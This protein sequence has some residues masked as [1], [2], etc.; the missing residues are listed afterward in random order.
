VTDVT[1]S[2]DA[3]A[4]GRLAGSAGLLLVRKIAASVLSALSSIVVVRCL[5]PAHFGA[6]AAGLAAYYLLTALTDF[7]F[8][9]VLGLAI[10]RGEGDRPGYARL[11]LRIAVC[12]SGLA[13]AAGVVVAALFAIGTVRGG[14][15]LVLVPAIGFAG[16]SVVRQFFYARH[17]VGRM[18]RIDLATTAGSTVVIVGAALAGAPAVVLAGVASAASVLNSVLVLQ[19]AARWFRPGPIEPGAAGRVIREAYPIGVASFLATAY[20]SIDVVIISALFPAETVGRYASAVKVLSILTIL[21]GLVMSIA[22]PQIAA[23]FSD[24]ERLGTLLTR[25]WHWLASLVLPALVCVGVNA[26]G[27]MRILFGDAYASA[28]GILR[29]LLLSGAVA[30]LSNLF[31]VVVMAASRS[32]WLL[33]QNVV[34]LALNVGGNLLL[35]PRFGIA[36][37]AW[38]TVLTEAFVCGGSWLLLRHR[39]PAAALLR[40][41]VLPVIATVAAVGVG[42][43]FAAH[44]WVALSLSAV[45][46]V[47]LLTALRGWPEEFLRLLPGRSRTSGTVVKP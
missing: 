6:Y 17:E 11:V 44:P 33:T 14:T 27:V 34:A 15:L 37:A 16:T 47:V 20:V 21:P 43:G 4:A 40:V 24:P 36:A 26:S 8:G 5:G 3:G 38:L 29:V 12:W 2:T 19:A 9:Q 45:L 42:A 10:G 41:S 22:L 7:G 31:G 32:R 1:E 30:L 23:D 25:L 28:G 13:A 35:A 18:A 46:Y 39:I